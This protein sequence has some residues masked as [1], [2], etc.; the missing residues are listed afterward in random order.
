MVRSPRQRASRT[1]CGSLLSRE[2]LPDFP[3]YRDV[4]AAARD[5]LR[6]QQGV[7][8]GQRVE[9]NGRIGVVR[10][11]QVHV[12]AQRP[13]QRVGQRGAAVG[14]HVRHLRAAAVLGQQVEPRSEEHTS[15]LQSL[16]RISYAVFCLKKK[17]S[18]KQ[19]TQTNN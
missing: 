4:A 16:M 9:R 17:K 19:K 7:G 3:L 8:G 6:R 14:Q 10:R 13:Q 15:E 18:Y 5:D 11:V 2:A 1:M 12:P